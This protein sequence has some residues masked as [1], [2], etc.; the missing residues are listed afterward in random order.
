MVFE[1]EERVTDLLQE[2]VPD[3]VCQLPDP[4]FTS[5]LLKATLSEA[6]PVTVMVEVENTCPFAGYVIDTVG[7]WF[8]PFNLI[9]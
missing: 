3:A 4:S 6:V 9:K 5:T 7:G 8:S 1:P 2:V